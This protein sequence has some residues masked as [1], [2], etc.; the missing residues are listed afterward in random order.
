MLLGLLPTLRSLRLTACQ[1][2]ENRREA[3][4]SELAQGR[5]DQILA[6]SEAVINLKV[7]LFELME[8]NSAVFSTSDGE[9]QQL[10]VR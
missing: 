9:D 10:G 3:S 2:H 8:M 7:T 1:S 6:D 4:S 5:A